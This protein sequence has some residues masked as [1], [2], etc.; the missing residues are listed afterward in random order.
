MKLRPGASPT[1]PSLRTLRT[2][3][4]LAVSAA[5]IRRCYP[6]M[7]QLRPHLSA[8]QFQRQVRRQQRRGGYRLAYLEHRGAVRA[9]AGFRVT[10]CLMW[11]RFLY[12]DDL[13]TAAAVRSHGYG[14]A[15]F[16]WM[17]RRARAEGCAE[18]HLDSGVQRFAAPRFYLAQ[19]L[20]LT[21]HHFAL[22][23]D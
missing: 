10:E 3:V 16:A 22:K 9:V 19:R 18:L 13:V 1:G 21:C 14:Q 5:A 17:V 20:E 2:T 8:D 12:V 6:V 11:G 7:V 23:L 4:H 15:L